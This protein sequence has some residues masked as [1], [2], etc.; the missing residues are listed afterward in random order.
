VDVLSPTGTA[1][2]HDL[3]GFYGY[4]NWDQMEPPDDPPDYVKGAMKA[5]GFAGPPDYYVKR[6]PLR[7]L[8]RSETWKRAAGTTRTA[9]NAP[10]IGDYLTV[11]YLKT[12]P[13]KQAAYLDL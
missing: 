13:E 4:E 3:I 10:K 8:V 2:E 9:D 7:D 12:E 6:D 11:G 5:L 1:E